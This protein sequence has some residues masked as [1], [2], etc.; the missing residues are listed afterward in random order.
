MSSKDTQPPP[1]QDREFAFRQA[2]GQLPISE[3]IAEKDFWVCWAL[4]RLTA[5]HSSAELPDFTFKGG[6]S[7]SKVYKLI[8][9]FSEDIDL[10]LDR[11]HQ[12]IRIEGEYD[13]MEPGL[14]KTR[15]ERLVKKI[16]QRTAELVQG[17]L[18]DAINS[19]FTEAIDADEEWTLAPDESDQSRLTLRFN[20]PKT[21][22]QPAS[23]PVPP[24]VRLEYG[25]SDRHPSADRTIQAYAADAVP[26]LDGCPPVTVNV[27]EAGRTFWEKVTALHQFHHIAAARKG[28]AADRHARHYY[29]VYQLSK[30]DDADNW[31]NDVR[32]LED[33]VRFKAI[34]F[35]DTKA[36][37]DEAR[38]GSLRLVPQEQAVEKLRADY[39]SMREY[40][41]GDRPQWSVLITALSELE[42][43]VNQ[44]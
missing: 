1:R 12:A 38:R 28:W 6:T 40:F 32:L 24:A 3:A 2:A 20:Y 8:E 39:E 10:S 23:S 16:R 26:D 9:R 7:L 4:G 31:I 14:S 42:N 11:A 44:A 43:R 22:D 29:D 27:L 21:F 13:P 36:R 25:V 19:D 41:T 5:V 15:R 17:P 35:R 30:A 34:F 33:V 37:W 18:L